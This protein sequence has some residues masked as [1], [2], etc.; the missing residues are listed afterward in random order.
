MPSFDAMLAFAEHCKAHVPHVVLTV[1]DHVESEEEIEKCR[2][3]CEERGL[4][5]R[6]RPYEDH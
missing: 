6:V 1:V 3:L 2:R 5:L 4:T